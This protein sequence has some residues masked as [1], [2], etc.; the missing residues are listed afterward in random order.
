[1]RNLTV[2]AFAFCTASLVG[3]CASDSDCSK[4]S[5]CPEGRICRNGLCALNITGL[6]TLADADA[7][8]DIPLDCVAAVPGDLVMTEIMADP[9]SGADYDGNGI[10]STT[11]DEFVEIVN[12]SNHPV[13]LTQVELMVNAKEFKLGSL[14]LNPN[15]ARVS[16]GTGGLPSLTNTSG[17]VQLFIAGT[18]VQTHTYGA[19]AGKDSSITLSR[20]LDPTSDWVVHKTVYGT[21]ASPGKCG[22]GND[23]PEC[24]GVGP[25]PDGDTTGSDL[26]DS[27]E[28][29]TNCSDLPVAGDLVINEVLAKPTGGTGGDAN[30]DGTVN[31]DDEFVEVVNVSTKTLLLDGLKIADNGANV[32]TVPGGLCL[33]PNQAV[34]AFSKYTGTGSFPGALVFGTKSLSLNDTGDSVILKSAAD[35]VLAQM[36]YGSAAAA[37][38]FVREADLDPL[39]NF[40]RH[41]VAPNASGRKMSPGTC[42]NGNAFPD[43]AGTVVVEE[44]DATDTIDSTDAS[45]IGDTQTADVPS[46]TNEDVGPSCGPAPALGDLVL[47]E[48]LFDPTGI[49]ANGDG[50]VNTTED[51]FVEILNRSS[52]SVSLAGVKVGDAQSASRYTFGAVCLGPNEAVVVFGKG[53]VHLSASGKVV[54]DATAHPLSLNNSATAGDPEHVK[55]TGTLGELLVDESF[56]G[57]TLIPAAQSVVRS[58][59]LTGAWTKHKTAN[60]GAAASPGQCIG[61]QP[62]PGC[63]IP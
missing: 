25:G 8:P 45:D 49:D 26:G 50:T 17:T 20:Q 46:D 61:L 59:D 31:S 43:C 56:S 1:M 52:A 51:E 4:D 37:E 7:L 58:P 60:P 22:N 34:V 55:V 47:N 48:V 16:F 21:S 40:V 24:D 5:D 35:E 18:S 14:C 63:L 33:Q 9:P 39:A 10:P 62:F 53:A 30:G 15:E 36:S 6:D 3:A 19:E 38:S 23:F 29:I 11:E 13:A 57:T 44:P 27:P 12:V 28:V 42:Q 41:S 54:L 32:V 2:M